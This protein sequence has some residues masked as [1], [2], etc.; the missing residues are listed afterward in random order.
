MKRRAVYLKMVSF[1]KFLRAKTSRT[2]MKEWPFKR[3]KAS[4]RY[5][6]HAHKLSVRSMNGEILFW[7]DYNIS[8]FRY[9]KANL[10]FKFLASSLIIQER[11]LPHSCPFWHW[12]LKVSILA[13]FV[14]QSF[15]HQ[16]PIA[17]ANQL[18]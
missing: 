7:T 14:L 1:L 9:D 2:K 10:S 8:E 12:W 6:Q 17:H 16:F 18:Y 11:L 4:N 13:E 5:T 3:I 15:V